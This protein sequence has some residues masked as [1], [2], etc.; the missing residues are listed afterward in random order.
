M[1]YDAYE[2]INSTKNLAQS[3]LSHNNNGSGN[4]NG[5]IKQ[6]NRDDCCRKTET[7]KKSK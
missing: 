2:I 5:I 1:L 6:T 4:G 3:A 7:K